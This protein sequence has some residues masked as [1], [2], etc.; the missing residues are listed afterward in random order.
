MSRR[1][2]ELA[3][4]QMLMSGYGHYSR[5]EENKAFNAFL[6]GID[7][8]FEYSWSEFPL[9]QQPLRAIKNHLICFVA[10]TCRYAADLGADD[11]RCYALSDYYINEIENR[12]DIQNWKDMILEISQH[13]VE[14]V[15]LGSEKKYSLPIQKAVRYIRQH[16]YETCRL[17]D[18]A[19]AI[20]VHPSYLSSLFKKETGV[21]L[22]HF[23]REMK[24]N[25]AKNMLRD[26]EYSE[27]EIAEML[28]YQS[29]S[30]FCKVFREVH[31][32]SP[33]EFA[34]GE[35]GLAGELST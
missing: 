31:S 2:A 26:G 5:A 30:Y 25:E 29:L 24:M 10:V 4:K 7:T 6:K 1:Q 21:S 17:Q 19:A 28:G 14:Q 27:S 34:M 11:E 22:T 33:R 12:A 20:G 3:M 16:L 15:R 18:V 23:V 35:M 8:Q 32:C 9:A 13:Y